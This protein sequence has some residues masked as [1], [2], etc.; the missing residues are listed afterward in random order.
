MKLVYTVEKKPYPSQRHIYPSESNKGGTG[1]Y[2]TGCHYLLISW[3]I[4]RKASVWRFLVTSEFPCMLSRWHQWT[5][6][7]F[8]DGPRTKKPCQHDCKANAGD[9]LAKTKLRKSLL[10][11]CKKIEIRNKNL[12]DLKAE[13]LGV[14]RRISVPSIE[15]V[16]ELVVLT[17][18]LKSH[19]ASRRGE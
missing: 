8:S 7:V 2:Y 12:Q 19:G 11:R 18:K 16:K 13:T 3:E 9:V 10:K 4:T 17:V 15:T 6:F 5:I 1:N 14:C